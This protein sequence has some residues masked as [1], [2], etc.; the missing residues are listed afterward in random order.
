MI[1]FPAWFF[2]GDSEMN[3]HRLKPHLLLPGQY[4]LKDVLHVNGPL[5]TEGIEEAVL[6]AIRLGK[7]D[8]E[9]RGT[10]VVIL[11]DVKEET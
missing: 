8:Y 1:D 7:C 11:G 3:T 9:A 10:D 5:T 2:C 6:E 4:L